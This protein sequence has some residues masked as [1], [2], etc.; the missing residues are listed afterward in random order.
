[1]A[2]RPPTKRPYLTPYD[3][4]FASGPVFLKPASLE[5]ARAQFAEPADGELLWRVFESFEAS[6]QVGEGLRLGLN[7]RLVNKAAKDA[8]RIGTNCA[9][10]GVIR[11]AR[12]ARVTIG[13]TVYVGDGVI[14]DALSS[15]EIGD[16]TLIAH[17][18][19]IFDNNSHPVD[20]AEREAHFRSII[21]LQADRGVKI[22]SA[23][24]KVGRRCWLGFNAAVMKGVTL[25]DDAIVAAAAM[26]VRDVEAKTIVAG[27]PAQVIKQ[28]DAPAAPVAS[29]GA[30]PASG[31][32]RR[33]FSSRRARRADA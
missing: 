1:M 17:G 21:G 12:G 25:G 31:W 19:Q 24:V 13:D 26:I 23:P 22:G 30:R 33:L 11:C 29:V 3:H 14:M 18:A 15:I 6:A 5:A 27:N 20:A 28:L 8:V 10:R 32:L 7:A 16:A 4:A 2:P 9:I